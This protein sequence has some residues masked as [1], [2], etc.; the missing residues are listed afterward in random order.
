MASLNYQHSALRQYQSMDVASEVHVASPHKLIEMLL[1]G[2]L[3]RIARAKGAIMRRDIELKIESI[4]SACAIIENLLISLDLKA[5]GT[6]ASNLAS[7]YDYM[8]RR[9]VYANAHNDIPALEEVSRLLGEIKSA[10][11]AIP[12]S[13]RSSTVS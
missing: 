13:L 2:A 10:W 9:L 5:G 11:D 7:L 12:V 6:I 3:A 8:L 1:A 4:L